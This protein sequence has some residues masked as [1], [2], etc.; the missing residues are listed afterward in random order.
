MM[1]R[2]GMASTSVKKHSEMAVH[3]LVACMKLGVLGTYKLEAIKSQRKLHGGGQSGENIQR[4]VHQR[5]VPL[6]RF[7]YRPDALSWKMSL[8]LECIGSG[9][10]TPAALLFHSRLLGKIQSREGMPDSPH[11]SSVLPLMLVVLLL[12]FIFLLAGFS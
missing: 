2:T 10:P 8:R 3:I 12:A 7:V 4:T 1:N 6:L 9:V 11:G 5:K